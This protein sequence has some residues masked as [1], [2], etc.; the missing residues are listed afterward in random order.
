MSGSRRTLFALGTL[1]A[2]GAGLIAQDEVQPDVVLEGH[3]ADVYD[4]SFS[5]DGALLATA[6]FDQTIRIWG[7][8][9]GKPVA[10][11]AGHQGK[12]LCVDFS[13]DGRSLASGGED[14]TVKLWDVPAGGQNGVFRQEGDVNAFDL[15]RDG[16]WLLTGASD[17]TVRLWS[18]ASGK[19]ELKLGGD[20]GVLRAVA[21]SADSRRAAAAG[22]DRVLRLWDVSSVTAPPQAAAEQAAAPGA[23]A[24]VIPEG[25]AWRY[26][27]GKA[28]PPPEWSRPEFDA[29]SWAEGASG[30]GY[31]SSAD[32]LATVKTR[33]DDMAGG[34]GYLS[35]FA[36]AV[37]K[38]DDPK[39]VEKLSLQ[40]LVDDGFV[41]YL[42]GEEVGRA[43]VEGSPP[44]FNQGAGSSGEPMPVTIDLTPH[45]GKLRSGDNALCVQG[46]NAGAS[47]SDFV[48]T[49]VLSA[50]FR[51]AA[52][53]E[54]K[55]EERPAPA[56]TLIKLEGSAGPIVAV[57]WSPGGGLV[58]AGG[59]DTKIAIWQA[60]GKP[61]KTL[62]QGGA[63]KAL[64]FL[65]EERLAAAGQGAA[66]KVW[67]V[68]AGTVEKELQG[69]QGDITALAASPDRSRLAS[70]SQDGSVRL[71]DAG[72]L[73]ELRALAGHEGPVTAV[74]F[75]ADGKVLITGGADKTVRTWSVED[76][77]EARKYQHPSAVGAVAAAPGETYYSAGGVKEVNEWRQVS[78]DAKRTL[79]G[80]GAAVHAVAFAPGGEAVASAGS[81]KTIRLWNP[82]DGAQ[83]R[84]I[85]AHEASIYALA[86]AA[87][88]TMLASG[89]FDRIVKVWNPADGAELKKLEGHREGV[90]CLRFSDDGQ[91]L[92]TGSSD[93]TLRK[94]ALGDGKEVAVFE[95]HPGWVCGVEILPGGASLV[96]VDYGGNL[97][98]W[99]IA[100]A[101]PESR[102]KVFTVVYDLALSPDGA[103][104]GTA[105]L[106]ATAFLLKP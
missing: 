73:K 64:A 103:W 65:G 57:A 86:Y 40:V 102:R 41:A 27:K 88:G 15:A 38:L 72:E 1:L 17:G 23:A 75:A 51:P 20:A 50:V 29:S 56:S 6:S 48:L 53:E 21:L 92:Y 83:L 104:L 76:G 49:P 34:G 35:L 66:I 24:A 10:T 58:A 14:K 89:G 36:R 62:E 69:H 68:A 30:F 13:A 12:V 59:D 71:W 93:R 91:F 60:D 11:L 70:A 4:L 99:N 74:A 63:L 79:A 101:K 78:A 2:A 95:G 33:L 94:W 47:S 85:N 100:E 97:I 5:P 18:R 31:S 28:A 22:E 82:A 52:K 7:V 84:A 44:A 25:H 105:N 16:K 96:S 32:E 98:R 87:D 77:K 37:F 106:S 26:L 80:H 8:G 90:F 39:R 46:H 43:N 19:E 42:N 54:E 81:D 3:E 67:N 9:A 45:A 55:K 61:L